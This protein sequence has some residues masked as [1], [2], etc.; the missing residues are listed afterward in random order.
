MGTGQTNTDAMVVTVSGTAGPFAVSSQNVENSSWV[1][2]TNQTISW[3]VN[4]TNTLVGSS[5]V[6]IKLST[7]GGLTFPIFLA[8][9]TLNDGSEVI[10][11]PNLTAT[12]CRILIEPTANIYY[13]IN[14]KPFAIGYAVSSSCATYAFS[15]PIAIPDGTTTYT[16]RM[17]TV[18]SS[19]GVVSDVNFALS[20]THS[21]LSDVQIEVVS[22]QGKTVKLFDKGCG[23]TNG[24]L[25]LNYDDGGNV[26]SCSTT[27]SQIV[28]PIE[29]LSAF[30]GQ[31]P[32]GVWKLRFRDYDAGRSGT[33][34]SAAITI[35]T[36][37]FTLGLSDF[38]MSGFNLY[39]NPSSGDFN[40]QFTSGSANGVKVLVHDLLGRKLFEKE[41]ETTSNFNEKIRLKNVLAGLYLLTVVD[42]ERKEVRKIVIE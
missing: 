4:N 19:D 24:N 20:L 31:N 35:C 32:E 5:N 28:V 1:Q 21:Y 15:T 26:L 27:S 11:V 38:K 22:P 3:T 29:L 16:E 12:N 9:N 17:I 7:D 18:P 23:A 37:N 13:A 25:I 39:P 40:I 30:N 14:S 33:I 42:G 41:F 34:N 2:G 6:N 36:Q 10:L 8:T